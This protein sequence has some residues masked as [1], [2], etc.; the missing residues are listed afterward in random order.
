MSTTSWIWALIALVIIGF[1]AWWYTAKAPTTASPATENN[2]DQGLPDNG[3]TAGVD[4]DVSV[5]PKT[6]AITYG[7]DGFSPAEVTV[8]KGD[9]VTWTNQ[10]GGGMWVASAPHP[11]HTG[12]DGTDRATH[13]A[14]GY[15]G[16]KPFDQC[17]IGS[18]FS[19]TFD[20]AGTWPYHNHS[21]AGKFGKV[22]V[23]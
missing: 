17:A 8:K 13:C 6:V 15:A 23:Q 5:A 19:F 14:A 12:Y 16:A 2:T 9:T 1:G 4:V 22:V 10:G 11:G 3:V 7:P 18:S 21:N 20:K